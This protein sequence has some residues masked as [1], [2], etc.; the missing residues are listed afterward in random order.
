MRVI[1]QCLLI[2]MAAGWGFDAHR[3][4][5][6]IA[7]QFVRGSTK[8]MIA[9]LLDVPETGRSVDRAMI[10]A[11]VWADSQGWSDELHFSHTPYQ[12]CSSFVMER[13]C[14]FGGSGRCIVSALSEFAMTLTNI[15]APKEERT[16][17]LKFLLHLVGDLHNPLHL[18]F[19]EDFGG[20]AI[21]VTVNGVVSTLHE[22]WDG[23][24]V[25]TKQT[26]LS[27]AL[28][29]G[30]PLEPWALSEHL[31]DALPDANAA[32]RY[33]VVVTSA[34]LATPA[35]ATALMARMASGIT[36]TYTCEFAYQLDSGAYIDRQEVLPELYIDSRAE[37]AMD[38]LKMAGIR[39]AEILNAVTLVVKTKQ[40][41]A[42]VVV[43]TRPPSMVR[44]ENNPYFCLD[45][46]FDVDSLVFTGAADDGAVEGLDVA[47]PEASQPECVG[48][49]PR[50]TTP[51]PTTTT[52]SPDE[53]K[54][55]KRMRE[56]ARKALRKRLV[57]GV[58]L[59]KAVLIK[60]RGHLI[61][62][63]VDMVTPKYFPNQ[64]DI[65]QVSFG[66]NRDS[67]PVSFFFD[68]AFFGRQ[69]YSPELVGKTLYKIRDLPYV[70]PMLPP[71]SAPEDGDELSDDESEAAEPPS[72]SFKRFERKMEPIANAVKVGSSRLVFSS[73]P[74]ADIPDLAERLFGWSDGANGAADEAK[75]A[76]D[77]LKKKARDARVKENKRLRQIYGFLPTKEQVWDDQF[78][79]QMEHVCI[80]RHEHIIF[81]VHAETMKNKTAPAI[82]ANIFKAYGGN[83]DLSFP[84][85]LIIDQRIYDGELT[86]FI[87]HN[88]QLLHARNKKLSR[89]L[90]SQRPS[91][92]RELRDV[93]L[94]Y[95]GTDPKRIQQMH[96]VTMLHSK[97]ANVEESYFK[98]TWS[99]HQQDAEKPVV[100]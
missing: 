70:Q 18:G 85:Y 23:H 54:A 52:L 84:F 71:A 56:K 74:E 83:V 8:R 69:L 95:F 72:L 9:D 86:P 34:D 13:D 48:A 2:T 32:S 89:Q 43:T 60:R 1:V 15:T 19:A 41:A 38:L 22:V 25:R 92:F 58:D 87:N 98:I 55:A 14:G 42:G 77:K 26:E 64:F 59:E 79:G 27:D 66:G 53:V 88:I 82:K 68:G 35:A 44:L 29:E 28:P 99:I 62:T 91:I 20:N 96:E 17:A 93:N 78:K 50:T 24:L 76:A 30:N 46:D 80:Y 100:F 39:L 4:V 63:R 21:D 81:Y 73:D 47:T 97:P 40:R 3:V 31:L 33:S 45:I 37:I 6:K 12:N 7:S 90:E 11:S 61:I 49:P 65:F 94:V 5:A 75:K 51:A 16:D 67:A 57:D 36:E 10:D